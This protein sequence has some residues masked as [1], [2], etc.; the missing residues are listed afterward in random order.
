[1]DE[2]EPIIISAINRYAY[3]PRRCALAHIEQMWTETVH[4]A[5]GNEV[6]E[7]VDVDSSHIMA[8]IRYERA[9]PIWSKRLNL[10]GKADLVEF[11]GDI[12]YPVEYKVGRRKSFENDALQLCAQAV[13]LEEMLNVT[14][15]KGALYW[16]GSRKRKEITFTPAMRARLEEVVTAVHE[17]IAERLVP[18]P[19]NDKRCKDCSLKESCLPHVVGNQ[20]LSRKAERELFVISDMKEG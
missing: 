16:H 17:M 9:L 13:C 18:P 10:T 6:H 14:V 15:E 4:T 1:M 11:H 8:G 7:N 20:A 12:P 2:D 19:V 5:R 3:C